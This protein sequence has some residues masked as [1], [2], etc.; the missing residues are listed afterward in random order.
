MSY[1]SIPLFVGAYL[2]LAAVVF[3]LAAVHRRR[4]IAGPVRVRPADLRP[5]QVGYLN[6]GARLAVYA[7]LTRLRAVGAVRVVGRGPRLRTPRPLPADATPLE[8]A[9]YT[10][11][12]DLVTQQGLRADT[13]V[14]AAVGEIR[15]GLVELGLLLGPRT[16]RSARRGAWVMLGLVAV[17]AVRWTLGLGAGRPSLYSGLATLL[18]AVGFV[19]LAT[20]IPR[21]S[22]AAGAM[23][24]E[25]RR[26]HQHLH[27]DQRPALA[28]YGPAAA[29]LGVAL[30]GTGVLWYLD[31][32]MGSEA[33]AEQ[34]GLGTGLSGAVGASCGGGSYGGGC[35]GG[36][37]GGG[38]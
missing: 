10:A 29:A 19:V 32:V 22:A 33:L 2:G 16:R 34:A 14:V 1:R 36:G 23:L 18:V 8:K 28:T 27:P 11:A 35:G 6:A 12:G 5:E 7:A 4:V 15:D 37:C 30:F 21:E 31:P 24:A 17:G 13:A 20:R 38:G 25:L 9:V 3:A 26:A